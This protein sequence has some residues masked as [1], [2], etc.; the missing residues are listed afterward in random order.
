MYEIKVKETSNRHNRHLTQMK[1]G[2][3]YICRSDAEQDL[4]IIGTYW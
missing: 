4:G 3:R 2:V 1:R